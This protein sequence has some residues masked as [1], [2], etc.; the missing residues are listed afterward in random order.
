MPSRFTIVPHMSRLRPPLLEWRAD[1]SAVFSSAHD[2]SA[3]H[4]P[5]TASP[6]SAFTDPIIEAAITHPR[7]TANRLN[8]HASSRSEGA[9]VAQPALRNG[10]GRAQR[11]A[12]K[13][14]ERSD[15]AKNIEQRGIEARRRG[16][17]WRKVGPGDE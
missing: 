7:A 1:V 8:I 6:E 9:R 15:A 3:R 10:D 16:E 5:L 11:F 12:E 13:P 4:A 17:R 2:G 14:R